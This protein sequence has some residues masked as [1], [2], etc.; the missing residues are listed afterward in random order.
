M[1]Q[2]R[3]GRHIKA[4][5]S[6]ANLLLTALHLCGIDKESIGDSTKPITL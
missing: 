1:G 4:P 2:H 3:G 5:G 6:S